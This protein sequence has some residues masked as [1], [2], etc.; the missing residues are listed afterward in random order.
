MPRRSPIAY[1]WDVRDA[2]QR[3]EQVLNGVAQQQYLDDDLRRLAAERLLIIVG[4]AVNNLARTD[5]ELAQELG[6]AGSIVAFRN[7]LVHGY[8]QSDRAK[9]WDVLVNHV[10]V[11][12]TNAD[13]IWGRFS[14]LYE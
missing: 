4:E 2:C 7:V 6:E 13:R 14:H 10:P 1:A 11:L 12:R 9:V 8:F 5:P 3:L